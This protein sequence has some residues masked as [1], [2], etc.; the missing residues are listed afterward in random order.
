MQAY[1]EILCDTVPLIQKHLDKIEAVKFRVEKE[2]P[3]SAEGDDAKE[4]GMALRVQ[5]EEELLQG[6]ECERRLN[7]RVYNRGWGFCIDL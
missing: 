5:F 1:A 4:C 6:E 2:G 3:K 7:D